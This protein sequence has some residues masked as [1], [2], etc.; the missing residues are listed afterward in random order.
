MTDIL[1]RSVPDTVADQLAD[2]AAAAG[3]DRM[4]YIRKLLV[5]HVAGP[6]VRERYAYR[7]YT[8]HGGRGKITRDSN[9]P[10]GT[11]ATFTGFSQEE[12]TVMQR[13]EDLVRRNEP[14]DREK[15]VALLQQTF[16]DVMEV[17]V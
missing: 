9:H 16:E 2:M 12:A 7:V 17:P 6:V 5:Q 11:G 8:A 14:G 1:I 10:N 15:A 4:A 13:V 3:E